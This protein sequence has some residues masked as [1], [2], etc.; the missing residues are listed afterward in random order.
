M[1]KPFAKSVQYLDR[2]VFVFQTP[3][4]QGALVIDKAESAAG[5][6]APDGGTTG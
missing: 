1:P 4:N 5:G 3:E 2:K 6:A